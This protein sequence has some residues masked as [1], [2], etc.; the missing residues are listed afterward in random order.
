MDWMNGR[1]GDLVTVNGAIRPTLRALPYDRGAHPM[2]M[3]HGGMMGHGGMGP[4]AIQPETLLTVLAPDRPK[5][6]PL[7]T[8]LA[9]LPRLDPAQATAL[10]RLELGED[11]M[12]AEFFINGQ[13]FDPNRVDIQAW[14]G[15]LEVWEIVN[16]GDMDH[17]FHLH[18]Y[19]FQVLAR[20]GKPVPYRAWKD[21]INIRK[22][23]TVRIAVPLQDFGGRTVYHCH[24]VE[25]E[26]RGMM[27]IL[28]VRP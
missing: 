17:P 12:Q 23:E 1:E 8:S 4:G 9:S 25:H 19:P 2:G 16:R 15:T 5:P 24:I 28:E 26:D 20:N 21:T 22:G 3:D 13:K 18:T 11:M 14:L 27:G 10:R 7:P 6:V